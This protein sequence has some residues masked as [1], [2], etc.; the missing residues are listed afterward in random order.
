[1]SANNI[2]R[3]C[4][5]AAKAHAVTSGLTLIANN[6][7]FAG[8][9]DEDKMPA[10]RVVIACE[11]AEPDGPGDDATWACTLEIQCVSVCDDTRAQAHH[12][13]CSEVFSQFM[14]GRYSLPEAIT[15]AAAAANPVVPFSCFDILPTN[16]ASRIIERHWFSSMF[17]RVICCGTPGPVIVPGEVPVAPELF[18]I[19]DPIGEDVHLEF[20]VSGSVSG[21]LL[22]RK[23]TGESEWTSIALGS[24]LTEYEDSNVLTSLPAGDVIEY[25]LRATN[26]FG[27]S[28]P[29]NVVCTLPQQS[30]YRCLC[31][32][33]ASDLPVD[34]V[35]QW[36]DRRWLQNHVI[37]ADPALQPLCFGDGNP[38]AKFV[39]FSGSGTGLAQTGKP[40]LVTPFSYDPTDFDPFSGGL[41]TRLSMFVVF[42]R[43]TTMPG[44]DGGGTLDKYL[45]RHGP[46]VR[47]MFIR[48]KDSQLPENNQFQATPDEGGVFGDPFPRYDFYD[49]NWHWAL[50]IRQGAAGGGSYVNL[51]YFDGV[52]VQS[53]E[54][55][56]ATFATIANFRIGGTENPG[57]FFWGDIA[58]VALW[59]D[60]IPVASLATYVNREYGL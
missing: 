44:T 56:P 59:Q 42:R 60:V 33:K 53:Y 20:V 54:S 13:F 15:A 41:A 1:M 32:Y 29:S 46:G 35:A 31:W 57:Q 14:T 47:G 58:E 11:Y 4:E 24:G 23:K 40:L 55:N 5:L 2:T 49:T 50:C 19:A 28:A 8:F 30:Q 7:I 39:R 38:I 21:L 12:E 52:F 9:D 16:Q 22:E 37:Q 27:N 48:C 6:R 17:F 3:L 36:V 10:P 26:A 45:I 25:R 34:F 51:L 18:I 43:T